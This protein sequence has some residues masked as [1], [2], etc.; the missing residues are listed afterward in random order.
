MFNGKTRY[1]WSCSILVLNY[2][3]FPHTCTSAKHVLKLVS[4]CSCSLTVSPKISNSQGADRVA[5]CVHRNGRVPGAA[6]SLGQ[7]E[8]RPNH[9]K[10]NHLYGLHMV[11]ILFVYCLY[12]VCIWFV[13]GLYMVCIWIICG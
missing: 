7:D 6:R 10:F 12:M 13:Y 11:C 5:W 8:G 4:L 9:P 2:Q 1:K 3:C